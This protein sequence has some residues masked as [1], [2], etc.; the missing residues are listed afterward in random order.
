MNFLR[1]NHNFSS[2]NFTVFLTYLMISASFSHPVLSIYL[3]RAFVFLKCHVAHI[4]SD[5]FGGSDRK[6]TL[7]SYCYTM[8]HTL[9][10]QMGIDITREQSSR[11]VISGTCVL[12]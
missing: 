2:S 4:Q 7:F 9:A 10:S 8:D 1:N 6:I 5:L 3:Y 12:S 11:K